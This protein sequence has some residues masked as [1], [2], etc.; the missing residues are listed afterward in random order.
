MSQEKPGG[1]SGAGGAASQITLLVPP[2]SDDRNV[3]FEVFGGESGSLPTGVSPER[4]VAGRYII[5]G[6]LGEGGMGRIFKV[7][8]RDLGKLFACGA[9]S[10]QGQ[11]DQCEAKGEDAGYYPSR[12]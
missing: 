1:P 9:G 3:P 8:H 7:R 6:S 4:I 10:C 11:I 12:P 2:E 5:E